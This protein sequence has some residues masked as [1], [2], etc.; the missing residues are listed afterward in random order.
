MSIFLSFELH[1][2]CLKLPLC[3]FIP[4]LRLYALAV[5][6]MNFFYAVTNLN[7][8]LVLLML[9]LKDDIG[10]VS[11]LVSEDSFYVHCSLFDNFYPS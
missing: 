9:L 6:A 8:F 11:V 4:I 5:L 10:A 7:L 1:V 3:I 2:L